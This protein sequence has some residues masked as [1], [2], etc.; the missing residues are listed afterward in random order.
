MGGLISFS[1]GATGIWIGIQGGEISGGIPFLPAETN[2]LIG[3]IVF[4]GGGLLCLW[5][6]SIAFRELWSV[7]RK[8]S[9]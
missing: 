9:S 3:R 8:S 6:S 2:N 1:L 7:F 4:A 5:I